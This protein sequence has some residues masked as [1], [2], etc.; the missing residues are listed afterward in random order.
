[1]PSGDLYGVRG[2]EA[3]RAAELLHDRN[4]AQVSD[5]VVVSKAGAPIGEQ[6]PLVSNRDEFL[7]DVLHIPR[8]EELP[9]FYH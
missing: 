3:D 9:F 2:V 5:E 1:M 7:D 4:R 6:N 8:G